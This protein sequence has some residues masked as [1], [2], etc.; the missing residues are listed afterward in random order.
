M[1]KKKP[2]GAKGRQ[3]EEQ[4][5]DYRPNEPFPDPHAQF[6]QAPPPPMHPDEAGPSRQAPYP[7]PYPPAY[8]PSITT[9]DPL[10]DMS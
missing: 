9:C 8:V 3:S 4:D 7:P 10:T 1:R 2:K 5:I 6:V